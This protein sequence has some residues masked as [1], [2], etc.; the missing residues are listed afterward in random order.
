MKRFYPIL[1]V[2]AVLLAGVMLHVWGLQAKSLYVL[3]VVFPGINLTGV[4]ELFRPRRIA[5][6]ILTTEAYGTPVRDRFYPAARRMAWD[7]TLVPREKVTDI[8]RSVPMVMRGAPGISI[9]HESSTFEYFEPQPIK[10]YDAVTAAEYNNAALV[11]MRAMEQWSDM[12]IDKH[13]GSHRQT[14]EA[15]CAM[16]LTG[17]VTYP[18]ADQTGN[19]IDNYVVVYGTPGSY[20]VLVDWTDSGTT[21]GG[22]YKDLI[23]M[24]LQLQRAGYN[25]RDVLVGLNISTAVHDKI[26]ALPNDNRSGAR[27]NDDGTFKVG[28]FNVVPFTEQYYHPGGPGGSPSAGYTASLGADEVLMYDA[29][30]PW[31]LLRCKLDN[32]KMAGTG[33]TEV[34][35]GAVVELSKDGGAIEL[36]FE[37]KPFPIPVPESTIRTDATST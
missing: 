7:A 34:G 13:I 25:P 20:T 22:I 12:R 2:A 32:F 14:I 36:F 18:I 30:A 6:R 11:S 16:S 21:I 24:K 27:K 26:E 8:T 19:I 17:T 29:M 31:S 9:R 5:H 4:S 37:S 10:T 33:S 23:N 35:L 1:C 28:E 15:L 3:A